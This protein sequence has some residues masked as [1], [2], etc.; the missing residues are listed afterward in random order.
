MNKRYRHGCRQCVLIAQN[1]K[2]DFHLHIEPG[3]KPS[4]FAKSDNSRLSLSVR[5]DVPKQGDVFWG[6]AVAALTGMGLR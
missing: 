5:F 2:A 4:L 6:T 1:D 3:Q